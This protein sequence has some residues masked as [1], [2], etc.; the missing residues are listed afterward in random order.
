MGDRRPSRNQRLLS[1][2]STTLFS[3][4]LISNVIL[5]PPS[6]AKAQTS[7]HTVH[8]TNSGDY[9][10]FSVA[11]LGDVNQDGIDDYAVGAPFGPIDTTNTQLY[12]GKV[13]VHSGLD[14]TT[15]Y[16][17]VGSNNFDFF[18]RAIAR[19][20]DLDGDNIADFL[21]GATGKFPACPSGTGGTPGYIS[22]RSGVDGHLLG[23]IAGGGVRFGA[24][25]D[26]VNDVD[27]DGKQ[28][29]IVG[30]SRSNCQSGN[31]CNLCKGSVS[32]YSSTTGSVLRSYVAST[33]GTLYGGAV[34]SVGDVNA[35]GIE[36]YGGTSSGSPFFTRIY[37]G[38]TGGT[39]YTY[40]KGA[41]GEAS[42]ALQGVGDVNGD[43]YADF[44]LGQSLSSVNKVEVFSG[45]TGAV[46]S[47][48][49]GNY[50]DDTYGFSIGGISDRNGDG[51]PDIVIGAPSLFSST[52][53]FVRIVSGITGG[54]IRTYIA[55]ASNIDFGWDVDGN[56]DF[57]GDGKKDLLF[58]ARMDSTR[59]FYLN[60]SVR[61]EAETGPPNR[62]VWFSPVNFRLY[63]NQ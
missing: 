50:A 28:D 6:A 51:N 9:F 2:C 33:F 11:T 30:V 45:K 18:G 23:T 13:T 43:G 34:A 49:Q 44:A 20:N 41:F 42:K 15:L 56:G 46:L 55:D 7:L 54:T 27:N 16:T 60:G 12:Q 17:I 63:L 53:E 32:V 62:E 57:N 47:T 21:V 4:F 58:G 59:G 35:D 29:I 37:S 31:P 26:A 61:I 3:I 8:G 36:D 48:S 40:S 39:L 38:S 5:L 25:L 24:V 19:I 14:S 1:N 10:G 52:S 22:I